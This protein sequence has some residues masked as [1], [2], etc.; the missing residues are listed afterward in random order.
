MK[1]IISILVVILVLLST[2]SMTVFAED[3]TNK[4][5][6]NLIEKI[7]TLNEDDVITVAIW[8]NY[9]GN[10]LIKKAKQLMWEEMQE[11]GTWEDPYRT[12]KDEEERRI[13]QKEFVDEQWRVYNKHMQNLE[14]NLTSDTIK[15]I[16]I[17][18]ENVIECAGPMIICKLKVSELQS[19]A[20]S[21]LVDFIELYED[22]PTE[23]PTNDDSSLFKN[24]FWQ[25]FKDVIDPFNVGID[26]ALPCY[27]EI[28]YHN[29]S[30]TQLMDWVL[31]STFSNGVTP[32]CIYGQ[33]GNKVVR[34]S[35]EYSPFDLGYCIYDINKQRF[36]S[37]E[38]AFDNLSEYEGLEEYINNSN[39]GSLIGDIDQDNSITILDALMMQK[40][41]VNLNNYPNNDSVDSELSEGDYNLVYGSKVNYISDFN[42]DGTRDIMDATA[43]QRYLANIK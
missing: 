39:I 41:L 26:T 40:C 8:V 42:R 18:Q 4:F 29:S 35:N 37:L 43:I 25:R 32:W 21:K 36:I 13:A 30:E 38:S 22:I 3:S 1:K 34:S 19:V 28:Y 5:T 9:D 16:N 11:N 17:P 33:F 14:K 6:D 24:I 7:K 31:I 2:F 10:E 20:S 27:K 12:Y 23:Q 15:D